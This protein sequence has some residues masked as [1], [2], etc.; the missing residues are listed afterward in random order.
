MFL[1]Y[2]IYRF[3]HDIRFDDKRFA[4]EFRADGKYEYFAP[5]QTGLFVQTTQD[6]GTIRNNNIL[7][8]CDILQPQEPALRAK[9]TMIFSSPDPRRYKQMMKNPPNVEYTMNTWSQME[10]MFLDERVETWYDDFV[11]FGGVPRHVTPSNLLRVDPHHKLKDAMNE[12]GASIAQ[13]FFESGDLGALDPD[14]L[15][16]HINPPATVEGGFDY[17]GRKEYS[18]ASDHIFKMLAMKYEATMLAGARRLFN[19]GGASNA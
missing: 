1:I 15:L 17:D 12:K 18:F 6:A 3:L 4:L 14:Y 13:R 8:L 10:L 19:V 7:V 2:F 16:I 5:N 11:V 9:W